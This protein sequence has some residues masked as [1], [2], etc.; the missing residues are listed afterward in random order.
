MH[1]AFE[2]FNRHYDH[3]YVLTLKR[4][5]NRQQKIARSL[6]GLQF[7][8]W[9]GKDK[10]DFT[11]DALVEQ[12]VYDEKA[13]RAIHRYH[14]PMTGGQIGCSWSHR[15]IYEDVVARG[16]KQVLIFEDDALPNLHALQLAADML[17]ELPDSAELMFWGYGDQYPPGTFSRVKQWM[18]HLQHSLGLLKWNHGMIDR[19]YPKPFSKN[20]YHAGFH[21]YTYAYALTQA[22][23]KKLLQLQ[24]PIKYIADNLLAW[25]CTNRW[26]EG[27][28]AAEK[29]FLHDEL[30]DGTPRDS[31]IQEG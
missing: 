20:L 16:Y 7:E 11:I 24:T 14:K 28:I 26:V 5:V 10:A 13:A 21:D 8:F 17:A 6:Q 1:S 19:L 29:I 27:Y 4:A 22:G 23:A 25:A 9:W 15:C 2:L 3:I 31:F 12:G 30:P 18:Y